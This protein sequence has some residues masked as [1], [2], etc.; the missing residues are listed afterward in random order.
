MAYEIPPTTLT[1][2]IFPWI[3]AE[4]RAYVYRQIALAKPTNRRAGQDQALRYLINL[5]LHL[6]RVLIQDCAVLYTENPTAPIFKFA[7]F[8]SD[9]FHTFASAS[10]Q[11]IHNANEHQRQYLENLPT[12]I[13]DNLR[14]SLESNRVQLLEHQ[15]RIEESNQNL[16]GAVGSLCNLVHT[17]IQVVT[18]KEPE[19]GLSESGTSLKRSAAAADL[20]GLE[21]A[22]RSIVAFHAVKHARYNP[23]S[24]PAAVPL[25]SPT[26]S[27]TVN[28][29]ALSASSTSANAVSDNI[30]HNTITTLG[31]ATTTPALTGS[32]LP[33]LVAS[34]FGTLF[35]DQ[36]FPV[37]HSNTDIYPQ[38]V[39]AITDLEQKFGEQLK[40]HTFEWRNDEWVPQISGLWKPPTVVNGEPIL[41]TVW[42]K[43]K[44]GL[45]GRFSLDQL[46]EHWG[47]RWRTNNSTLKSELSRRAKIVK[48]VEMLADERSWSV[49]Q[50]F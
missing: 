47:T 50:V 36:T 42:K 44:Q 45:D 2:Q 46:G 10:A 37:V 15:R 19:T 8:N 25:N 23:S 21:D 16:S 41:E 12:H 17:T 43:F 11:V 28:L 4:E 33:S 24:D 29:S 14:G 35:S 32:V 34:G 13:A 48:L 6:R 49:K 31:T 9:E 26:P 30:I 20:E 40:K 5:L 18:A 7:P 39:K 27:A 3:E 22:A 1:Q 38:Q